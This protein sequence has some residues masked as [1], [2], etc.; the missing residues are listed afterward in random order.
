TPVT[1]DLTFDIFSTN[2]SLEVIRSGKKYTVRSN[3]GNEN[4]KNKY[5]TTFNNNI[6]NAVRNE[7]SLIDGRKEISFN[8]HL[9]YSGEITLRYCLIF[10]NN[11]NKKIESKWFNKSIN[12]NSKNL[13]GTSKVPENAE[14]YK[15]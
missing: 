7:K 3:A 6:T 12:Q 9:S 1:F 11:E 13:D 8:M 2:K 14:T 4:A 5:L 15:I 10:F